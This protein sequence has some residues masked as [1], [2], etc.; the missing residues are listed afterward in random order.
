[1]IK[2]VGL[3]WPLDGH[4]AIDHEEVLHLVV[5]PDFFPGFTLLEDGFNDVE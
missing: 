3:N 2:L 5:L 4:D 1:V